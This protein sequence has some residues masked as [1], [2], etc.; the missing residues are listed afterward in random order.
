MVKYFMNY[1][2]YTLVDITHTG[3]YRHE[4]G[5]EIAKMQEQNFNTILQTLGLRSNVFYGGGPVTLE[6][7]G[8]LIGFNTD[9]IIR[10]WRFDWTTERENLYLKDEDPVGYLKD[11]FQLIPYIKGL[12]EAME[13]NYAVFNTTDPGA[14]IVFHLKQ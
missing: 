2:L 1:K 8:S 5:K 3:Q 14:N 10:V 12:N 9:E 4:H 13:Q 7:K 11:D 6:V